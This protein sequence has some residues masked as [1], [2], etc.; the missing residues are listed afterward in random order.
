M[1]INTKRHIGDN[2]YYLDSSG[3]VTRGN[4]SKVQVQV[5][6]TS[7]ARKDDTGAKWALK[8]EIYSVNP[9][10]GATDKLYQNSNKDLKLWEMFDTMQ[11][12][13]QHVADNYVN[14]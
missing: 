14:R 12:V 7:R 6:E 5:V 4:I 3:R 10:Q 11:E 9:Y 1:T 8:Y 2:C 13:L